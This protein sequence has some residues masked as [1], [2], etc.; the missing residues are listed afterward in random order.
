MLPTSAQ[1]RAARALLNL[2]QEHLAKVAGVSAPTLAAIEKG[3][4]DPRVSSV[5][6]V[7]DELE[8]LGVRFIG[9]GVDMIG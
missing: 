3:N 6:K 2:S 1:F 7:A 9:A 8:K 4:N 5:Q